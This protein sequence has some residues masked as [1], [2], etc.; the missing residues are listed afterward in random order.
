VNDEDPGDHKINEDDGYGED[1][2]I[3]GDYSYNIAVW[4]LLI[5][6]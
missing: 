5:I 6:Y 2:K 1:S 3:N 4:L